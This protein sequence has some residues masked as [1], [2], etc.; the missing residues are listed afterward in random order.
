MR[1]IASWLSRALPPSPVAAET[2]LR[3]PLTHS[4]VQRSPHR[5]SVACAVSMP[6][7]ISAS[8]STRRVMRPCGS[9]TWNDTTF[10]FFSHGAADMARLEQ[11]HADAAADHAAHRAAPADDARDAFLVD[12]VLRRHHEAAR[13]QV[14]ADHAR[15][16]H[17]VVRL[18]RDEGDVDRLLLRQLLHI[19]DVHGVDADGAV[20]RPRSCRRGA[21]PRRALPRHA[22]AM[23]RSA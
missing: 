13:C 7:S 8:S 4:L 6:S 14:L 10:G 16:P 19:G 2:P 17:R 12:A 3:M 21:C 5:L 15:R 22:R 23:D 20:L 1:R 18:H 11:L 9:P